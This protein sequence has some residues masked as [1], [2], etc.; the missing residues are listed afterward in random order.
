MKLDLA[1]FMYRCMSYVAFS[2][3]W[4]LGLRAHGL[5]LGLLPSVEG[6]VQGPLKVWR[7]HQAVLGT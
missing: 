1:R 4:G 3:L 5:G 2:G 7:L 6:S